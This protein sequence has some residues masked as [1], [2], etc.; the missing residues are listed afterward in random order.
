[1]DA[2]ARLDTIHLT[3]VRAPATLARELHEHARATSLMR[4]LAHHRLSTRAASAAF[5]LRAL[6]ARVFDLAPTG[7]RFPDETQPAGCLRSHDL[8]ALLSS[9]PE[10]VNY[11]KHGIP[12]THTIDVEPLADSTGNAVLYKVSK[13]VLISF[14]RIFSISIR[15]F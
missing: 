9:P 10:Q 4:R 3:L 12:F 15:R 14:L 11:T 13:Q 6:C 7:S 2:V 1:M 8:I 5:L